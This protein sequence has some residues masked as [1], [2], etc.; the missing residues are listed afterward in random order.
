M[1]KNLIEIRKKIQQTD[2]QILDLIKQRVELCEKALSCKIAINSKIHNPDVE[3]E[4]LR[5]ICQLNTSRLG[6]KSIKTIFQII[7]QEC[8]DFQIEILNN[9]ESK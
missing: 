3:N 7:I 1:N 5:K 8:R 9:N 4:K 6:S 2:L